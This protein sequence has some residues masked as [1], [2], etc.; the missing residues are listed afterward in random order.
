MLDNQH[1]IL[2]NY[3]QRMLEKDW[4]N[5]LLQSKDKITFKGKIT[6]IIAKNL[7]YGVIE[8]SKEL[9]N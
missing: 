1:W 7:G 6:K 8:V 4:Q 5:I 9:S 3:S 2:E